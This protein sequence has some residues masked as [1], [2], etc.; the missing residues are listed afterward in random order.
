MKKILSVFFLLI[1]VFFTTPLLAG[2]CDTTLNTNDSDGIT[3][4]DNDSLTISDGITVSKNNDDVI[5]TADKTGV[6]ILNYG[7]IQNSVDEKES[8]LNAPQNRN[9]SIT[10]H[11]TIKTTKKYGIYIEDSEQVTIT[12]NAGATIKTDYGGETASAEFGAIYGNN[13]GNC[14][15]G[16]CYNE[17]DS[18]NGQGLTLNNYGTITSWLRTVWGGSAE[19]EASKKINIYNH[20][21]GSII[22]E[23]S[24][25]FKFRYV[26]DFNLYNH[27]GGTL[28]SGTVS[29]SADFVIDTVNGTNVLIDNAGKILSGKR[30]AISCTD[31][32]NFTL[33]NSGDILANTGDTVYLLDLNGTNYVTN[34]GTIK[35]TTS[36]RP[37]HFKGSEGVTFENTGLVESA[38]QVAVDFNNNINPTIRN[39]GT[40]KSTANSAKVLDLRQSGTNQGTGG[41]IENYGTIIN[42][43]GGAGQS[44]RVGSG[45][46]PWNNLSII[47][48][49]TISSI[50][51]SILVQGGSS[52]S[53][54]N[55]TTKG[56]GT[57]VGEIDM[58]SAAVT[59]TL[60][61]SISKDQD[62]EIEDKTNMIIVDNLCGDD[63][64]AILDSSKNS[65]SDNSETNGYLRI[66]GEDPDLIS[67][68]K[69]YRSEIFLTKLR[70]LFNSVSYNKEET[71]FD[72]NQKRKN[73]YKSD[74]SG[75]SG[76]FGDNLPGGTVSSHFFMSYAN[77]RATFDNGEFTGSKNLALGYKKE[78]ENE[79]LKA[80]FVPI[81]GLGHTRVTDL[82]TETNQTL[83]D[84]LITQF[85][86][87]DAKI[88]KQKK[89][90]DH[91]FVTLEVESM[92]GLHRFP[93]Y[94]TNFT[95]G[96]V[97][98]DEAID[99]VLGAGF[100]VKYSNIN[101][102]GFIIQPY[103]NASYNNTFSNDIEVIAGGE[104]KEAGHVMNGVIAKRVG[105][106]ITKHTDD[107]SFSVNL[108]HGNQ[109][110][111]KEDMI[112]VS[113]SKKLQK[114]A[115]LRQEDEKIIPELENL[116]DQLEL[117]KENEKLKNITEKVAK[118]NSAMK[119]LIIELIKENQKLKTE[120]KLFK[121]N[122]D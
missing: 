121:K 70:N 114:I 45:S 43:T 61:C 73:I 115:K 55:V 14:D 38:T 49:G 63:T 2:D 103:L 66:Y 39:W 116:Y 51:E 13:I 81:I 4:S 76:F 8:A 11:G 36:G 87:V 69:K 34:S 10:N 28:Q 54:L 59:M 74:L 120:N 12:N 105:L 42:S 111:L 72:S 23:S 77:Q 48:S 84:I 91:E 80:S 108:E 27:K 16:G 20:A 58:E 92:Y 106:N 52:T 24:A 85:A 78:I 1:G 113:F 56:E 75:V 65:D 18:N 95:E 122:L 22:S 9:F 5:D 50:G 86:G 53:G 44:I 93:D 96:D 64:Y 102:N 3:C 89:F 71:F 32:T 46:T 100:T 7:I 19:G 98:V 101:K 83:D 110:G 68:N 15:D 35:N 112:G 109:G 6:S 40:L 37:L 33:N 88:E 97:S 94:V 17:T 47:N 82:E 79:K 107:I 31:C 117:I 118:E 104:N 30:Y 26:T 29:D 90:N 41:T 119:D 60:D 57:W 99:Q 21:G 67:N 62:I 25:T